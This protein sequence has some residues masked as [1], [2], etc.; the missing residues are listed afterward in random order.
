MYNYIM[1]HYCRSFN[2]NQEI[3]LCAICFDIYNEMQ[4]K[5]Y[6][7]N[8]AYV[9][10]FCAKSLDCIGRICPKCNKAVCKTHL[11]YHMNSSYCTKD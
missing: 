4:E 2:E 7:N 11:I 5:S 10:G 1:C 6:R 9:K 3:Y 8:P